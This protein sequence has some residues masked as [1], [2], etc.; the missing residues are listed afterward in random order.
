MPNAYGVD[1]QLNPITAN[2]Q[3]TATVASLGS[4]NYAVHLHVEA[5]TCSV[6]LLGANIDGT[7][8]ATTFKT[9][10]HIDGNAA[11]D[12][13]AEV[14][15]VPYKYVKMKVVAYAAATARATA[16]GVRA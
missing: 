7:T 14:S 4:N 13:Y 8:V 16:V 11:G 15:N 10:A 6:E 2:N 3:V 12:F 5:G 1:I 9:L